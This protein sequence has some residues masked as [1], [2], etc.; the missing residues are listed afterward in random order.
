M[1]EDPRKNDLTA[2]RPSTASK[3]FKP[4]RP[5]GPSI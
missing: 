3:L 4:S 1:K 2:D 5:S